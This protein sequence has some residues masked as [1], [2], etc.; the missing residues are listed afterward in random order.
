MISNFL[1]DNINITTTTTSL[2]TNV[3]AD[4]RQQLDTDRGVMPRLEAL[5]TAVE[6]LGEQQATMDT[7]CITVKM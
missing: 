5:E 3:I 6:W 2:I 7:H 1:P 4:L